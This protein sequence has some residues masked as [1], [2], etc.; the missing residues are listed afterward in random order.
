MALDRFTKNYLIGLV[1][2]AVAGLGWW[3]SS[4][5]ARV[6][7]I[8][9]M[10]AADGELATYPYQFH[11]LSLENGVAEIASPR[12]AE[13]PVIR[14]LRIVYP[15]YANASVTDSAVMAAQDR[16]VAVQS[17]AAKLVSEQDGVDAIR[18]TIDRNWYASQGIQLE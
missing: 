9:D 18:W 11:V 17:R 12:S 6:S 1:L 10:L 4:W 15:E 14:F 3:L 16:L 8:N 2:V 13:V 5:D 7:Q